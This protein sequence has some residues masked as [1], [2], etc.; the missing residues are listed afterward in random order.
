MSVARLERVEDEWRRLAERAG[1]PFLT[2]EWHRAWLAHHPRSRPLVGV[3][4]DGDGGV[5]GVLPLVSTRRGALRVLHFAGDDLGDAFAPLCAEGESAREIARLVAQAIGAGPRGWDVIVLGFIDVEVAWHPAFADALGGRISA[6]ERR[7]AECPVIDVAGATWT[8]YLAGRSRGF[9]K[10]TRRRR[11]RLDEDESSRFIGPGDGDAD[12]LTQTLFRLHDMRWNGRGGSSIDARSSRRTLADFNAAAAV[13][14]WLQLWQLDLDG[15]PVASEL[16]WRI[17]GRQTHF[18]GGFD[19][20]YAP[21]GVGI[22]LFAHVVED[23]FGSGADSLDLGRGL[24]AYKMQFATG[25]REATTL[26]LVRSGHPLR[27]LIASAM[28][29]R[30]L[31]KSLPRERLAALG[32]RLGQ[33]RRRPR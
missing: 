17:G 23:G 11:R 32:S 25:T 6:I 33:L 2:P 22:V 26:I 28:T 15:R 9:R 13:R 19:P 29:A 4:R 21:R 18:Q 3:V 20:D 24:S 31:L 10:E 27:P 1:V 16:A 12:D 30:R 7:R 5:L 14:G 8:D